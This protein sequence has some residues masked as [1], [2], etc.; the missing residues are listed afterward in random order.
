MLLTLGAC[1]GDLYFD[2]DGSCLMVAAPNGHTE[3]CPTQGATCHPQ[4]DN[5]G[6][7]ATADTCTCT[8]GAWVCPVHTCPPTASG[9]CPV[10][11]AIQPSGVCTGSLLCPTSVCGV[12]TWCTCDG[13][14]AGFGAWSCDTTDCDAGAS[15]GGAG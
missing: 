3:V 6:A 13:G 12:S 1:G 5:C 4:T 2:T 7:P 8:G 9:G 10:P 14:G 15:D 11:S